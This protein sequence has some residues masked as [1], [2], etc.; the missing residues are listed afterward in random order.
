MAGLKFDITGDNGNMLSALQG[1][2]NGV[3]QTQRVVEQGG[4]GIEQ[5]FGKIQSAATA[6]MGAFSAQQLASKVMS[7]RGEFQQLEVA[8]ETMLGSAEEANKLMNQLVKTAAT[9]PFDLQSVSQGAKQLLA[10]G[11]S[12]NEVNETLVRLGDI[13]AGLSVPLGDLVYLYGT[14]MVQGR[15]FSKDLHQFTG[16]GIPIAKEI[17]D[18]FGVAEDKILDLVEAGKVGA[19][20]VKKAIISMTSE[21]GR[22]GGLMEKQSHTITGQISN[23]EDAIDTMFNEIGKQ[24]EGGIN[25]G[26]ALVSKLVENWET[27]A[28]VL[29]TVAAAYGISKAAI[30]AY[31]VYQTIHNRLLQEAALQSKLAAMNNI[32]LSNSEAMAAARTTLFSASIKGLTAAIAA[33]PVGALTVG[34]T[35][36][37]SVIQLVNTDMDKMAVYTDKFGKDAA[38]TLTTLDTYSNTLL[39]LSDGHDKLKLSGSTSKKV[40]EELNSILADYGVTQIKE[41]DNIDV[42]NAKRE[43]AIQL[44]KEESI[45]R[46]RLNDIDAVSQEYQQATQDAQNQLVNDLSNAVYNKTGDT[47]LNKIFGSADEIRENAS[48]ISMIIGDVVRNN[49]NLIVNKSGEEYEKGMDKIRSKIQERMK[50]IGLSEE[51]INSQWADNGLFKSDDIIQKYVN[52]MQE[53]TVAQERHLDM[54][55]RSAEAERNAAS[56]SMD[57]GDKVAALERKLQGPTDGVHQLYKNIKELMS[58]YKDNTIGFHINFDGQFPSWMGKM[59]I[60]ELERLSKRFASIGANLKDGGSAIVN[61]KRY[62]K[63][64]ALQRSADYAEAAEDKQSKKDAAGK[65]A[66]RKAEEAAKDAEKNKKKY[67]NDAKRKAE[68]AK[69][70]QERIAEETI[71]RNKAI[72][73]YE[74]SVLEQQ[75]ETEL[76][77]RQHNIDLK[78]DSYEKEIKQINLNYDRLIAENEKRRKDMIEALK[79]NKVNEWL[80]KNPKATK[81]QEGNYRNSLNLTDSDLNVTQK[82]QLDEY[83]IIAVEQRRKSISELLIMQKNSLYEYLKEYG[84][85][86]E[87]MYA[88]TNEYDEKIAREK[89]ENRRKILEAEKKDALASAKSRNLALDIDWGAT[90]EGVGNVLKDIARDTLKEVEAYMKTA[91]FKALSPESK[92]SYADLRNNLRKEGVGDATS[93]FNFGIWGKIAE[94]TRGYQDA[95]K[96]LKE[97]TDAHTKAVEDLRKAEFDLSKATDET[98]KSIAKAKVESAKKT[99]NETET[100]QE[101][102]KTDADNAKQDLTDSTN[103]AAQGIHNFTSAL[104]EMSNGSLYGFAN[105]VTKLVTSLMK[106]SDGVGKGLSELGG[107]VG[108]IIGAILQIID[109]L[110]DAPAEFITSLLEKVDAAVQAIITELPNIIMDVIKGVANIVGSIIEGIGS[111]FGAKDGWMNGSNAKEVKETTERLTKSN[112][113]LQGSIDELRESI[114]KSGGAKAIDSYEEAYKNQEAVNRNTMEILKAQMS[115]H[116]NHHSNAY[117]WSLGDREY[118]QINDT[119]AKYKRENPI[120]KTAIESVHS[121]E[122]IYKLTPEQ[123]KAISVN[124]VELWSRMLDEGK[125]DKSEYWEKYVA[126]AGELEALTEKISDNLTQTSFDSLHDDFVSTIMDMDATASDF[127]DDFTEMMAR[128]Y[129]NA[130]VGDLMDDDLKKFKEKWTNKMNKEN[131]KVDFTKSEID[132]LRN[133][134][135]TLTDRALS[136]RNAMQE[137]TGYTGKQPEQN[138]T[139]NGVSSITYEQ[140]TNIDALLTAGNITRE[141]IKDLA[142]AVMANVSSMVT[143]SSSTNSA[144]LEIKNLMVYN[145]SY[146][147]DILKCSK[148]I[149]SEFAAKLDNVNRNLKELK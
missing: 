39:G 61:G 83:E 114:D 117:Y 93:P 128:A 41:G 38:T 7:V 113:A 19:A 112:A 31:N 26:L 9:T 130:A 123:M 125:Y 129:T 51:A 77:L 101:N 24:S 122:D 88:I 76:A 47:L 86:Q 16:R 68:E 42:V 107:K 121:L 80:N 35:A 94:Q 56:A 90:F 134:Y 99:V 137:A 32:T 54:V 143:F 44:I 133:D 43:Q 70:E 124:N 6:A 135:Q 58:Q 98:S 119:L 28:R 105:G 17:T 45:E 78:E 1:V 50:A 27:V 36:L 139:A 85:V 69:R 30:I 65:E 111:W 120:A 87:Q 64:Q 8:F 55:N 79:N 75:K 104:N 81:S 142:N 20:E 72:K 59:G 131:G 21:G 53:A 25:T 109:A 57:Y 106:G 34:L 108:G 10:Y 91:E 96:T 71:N 97:K 23:I 89:D 82:A 118:K 146:L 73:G 132:E 63:Q 140:A 11:T 74:E 4:A 149:Y 67:A 46:Q 84:T 49:M 136:I 37:L 110:G 18:Q 15:L 100:E 48:A 29:G 103:A 2:Q 147:E 144:V 13:A 141:Q 62:T 145:N 95:V 138:A 115:Y 66:K 60:P 102:A 22:F 52:S 12:A 127:A 40:L 148:S 116:D 92:K 3:R 126:L 33:N 14:T 5:V